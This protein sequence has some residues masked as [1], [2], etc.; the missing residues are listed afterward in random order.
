MKAS[1]SV[2]TDLAERAREMNRNQLARHYAVAWDTMKKWLNQAG[3]EAKA[4]DG[5]LVNTRPVP[6]DFRTMARIMPAVDLARHYRAGTSTVVRWF[7]ES[8]ARRLAPMVHNRKPV[9]ADFAEV[10]PR[11]HAKAICLHYAASPETVKRWLAETGLRPKVYD[12]R[13]H[14][15]P[16]GYVPAAVTGRVRSLYDD[17]ADTLRRERF[18]VFRCDQRGRF[19]Q[20][21]DFWRVGNSLLTG[22]DLLHR[23]AKYEQR[24]A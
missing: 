9:P 5:K 7:Q 6:D 20:K 21:G 10:A 19:E 14:P 22:E 12:Y 23:A 16:R 1:R 24:A 11:L 15:V 3:I 18:T 13:T 2:P 17:A 8:G 4:H